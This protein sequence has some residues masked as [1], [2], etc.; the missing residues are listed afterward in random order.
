[1]YACSGS[2]RRFTALYITAILRP[3]YVYISVVAH[4]HAGEFPSKLPLWRGDEELFI[5][6]NR[7][8]KLA[9]GTSAQM[10]LGSMAEGDF[11]ASIVVFCHARR[12]VLGLTPP[13]PK[14]FHFE[15]LLFWG[16]HY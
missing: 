16:A 15:S 2:A 4:S 9:F 12:F 1:M 5:G 7:E 13:K 3:Y 11:W 8:K 6:V 14:L 10:N